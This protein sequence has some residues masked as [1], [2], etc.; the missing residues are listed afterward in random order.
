MAKQLVNPLE[1]HVEKAM[2]GLAGLGLVAV[3]ALYLVTSPNQIEL[4]QDKVSPS[5]IDGKLAQRAGDV[6]GRLK[7]APLKSSTPALLFDDFAG[8]L[9]PLA[10]TP[11]PGT[12][13]I[14]PEVPIVDPQG[15][16]LGQAELVEVNR[17]AKPT[18]SQ[19]RGT[20]IVQ[21]AGGQSLHVP[22]DWVTVSALFD[23]AA[24]SE[25]QRLE[26]GALRDEVVLAPPQIQRRPRRPDGS[27]SD[28][29]W[30]DVKAWPAAYIPPAPVITIFE[31]GGKPVVD[32]DQ[33]KVMER[34]Y[35]D[36]QI[37][38][39]QLDILRP[40]PPEMARPTHWAL[41]IISSYRDVMKQDDEYLYPGDPPSADPID[42]YGLSGEASRRKETAAELS[43]AEKHA[44]DLQDGQ[45]LLESARKNK[46][47]ND[48][49][50]AYNFAQDVFNDRSA[51]SADRTK[52]ERL[53]AEAEQVQR[54]VIRALRAGAAPPAP[55]AQPI[56]DK[57]TRE[58]LPMQQVW[59]HDAAVNSIH[60][61]ETYQ[62]R[63][64]FRI[65]NRLAGLPDK[66]GKSELAATVFIAGEWSEPSDP[67]IIEPAS[68][69]YVTSD[70]QRGEEVGIE[71]F[72]W[73]GGVWVK[74]A[75]RIKATIGETIRDKQRVPAPAIDN[76]D[77]VDNPEVEFVADA[78]LVD[79]DF[80]RAFRERRA[81][82]TPNGVRFGA[83]FSSCSVVFV[84]S[85]GRLH[86]RLVA[87]DKLHPEKREMASRVWR[88]N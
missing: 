17:P 28:G 4:G 51:S 86:E 74:Q 52:A 9:Q 44:R 22:V 8:A 16:A 12:V 23:V 57:K 66:F 42:R 50:K 82:A 18:V 84:D 26:Y 60:N 83:P 36:L 24:Q 21:G 29:D 6:V 34:F 72:R 75:R 27:W 56:P 1:R 37:P 47:E 65:Y 39:T 88:P 45:K 70:N 19:G 85:Q 40:L 13:G 2:L 53:K 33:M 64:R 54:D 20:I 49:I 80:D 43:P 31:E 87:L 81:G 41:P 62:Y 7:A 15:T 71:F 32:K 69:F 79:I 59:A 77:V 5:T 3:I 55:G 10:S 25:L 61:G 30:T 76:P 73:F 11:L 58:K 63:M 35:A 48:A 78:T 68:K 46:S 38:R 67:V 14:S